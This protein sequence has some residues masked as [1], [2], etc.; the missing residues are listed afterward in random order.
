MENIGNILVSVGV[1]ALFIILLS[2]HS[3]LTFRAWNGTFTLRTFLVLWGVAFI[4]TFAWI[5]IGSVLLIFAVGPSLT[6][7]WYYTLAVTF[8]L[9]TQI[10]CDLLSWLPQ[11]P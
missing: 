6:P 3:F 11:F 10:N 9:P 1:I 2:F 4:T 5:S 7:T 8:G